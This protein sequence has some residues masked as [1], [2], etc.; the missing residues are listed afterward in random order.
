MKNLP[1]QTGA[2]SRLPLF[3][4]LLLTGGAVF[5]VMSHGSEYSPGYMY[6]MRGKVVRDADGNCL[7]TS[8]WSRSNAIAAC[9]PG[10]VAERSEDPPIRPAKARVTG[11]T[12][13]VD[14]TTLN[15][16]EAFEFNS[17][18]LSQKGKA[19]LAAAVAGHRDDYIHRINVAG[20]TDR[21]GNPEYNLGL[22]Q[23]R[24]DAVKAEL[25]ALGVPEERIR[26]AA[27][28]SEDPLVTCQGVADNALIECLAPNRRTE[29]SFIVPSIST[30]AAAELVAT[31]RQEK[32]KESNIAAMEPAIVD[33]PL[34]QRGF[35]DA[36]KIVGNGCSKEI[37]G[38]CDDVP[39]GGGRLMNCLEAHPDQ[40]SLGCRDAVVAGTAAIDTA[41]GN[42]NFFGVQ[43]GRDMKNH[44]ADVQPGE[45]RM[46]GCLKGNIMRVTKRCVDAL[47]ELHLIDESQYPFA[48]QKAAAP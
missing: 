32:I 5:P 24:A 16:G 10:V 1:Q 14:L 11:V 13:N 7:R 47:L 9:D 18:E 39:L 12:A 34:I 20:H 30:T 44:C 22:S 36:M 15:A 35:N 23:R 33:T 25:V 2:N 27:R 37:A 28:G 4:C 41:L 42:A 46:L 19:T 17:A 29:V 31:R 26:T 43:C 38:L 3:L 8:K 48:K 6:D 21:I 45:G 40:L